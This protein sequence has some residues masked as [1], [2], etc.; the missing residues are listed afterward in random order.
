MIL[1][2]IRLDAITFL[3]VLFACRHTCLVDPGHY[4]FHS[5]RHEHNIKPI[6]DHHACMIDLLGRFGRLDEVED[7]INNMSFEPDVS[8]WVALLSACRFH[9]NIEIGK[10][11]AQLLFDLEPQ[12][13][14]SYVLLSNIYSAAGRWDD[15]AKVRKMMKDRE[16]KKSQGAARL[17]S[18][19]EYMF[20]CQKIDHTLK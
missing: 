3:G 1:T 16:V 18:R 8:I 9:G 20:S 14:S 7:F 19:I 10:R 2:G 12:N 4:Y 5:M 11:V 17:R 13:T 15:A 6:M